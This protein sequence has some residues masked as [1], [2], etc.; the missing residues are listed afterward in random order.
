MTGDR[1]P[2]GERGPMGDKGYP[3]Y[4]GTQGVRGPRGLQGTVVLP[5]PAVFM[6]AA[7]V[8]TATLV[9]MFYMTYIVGAG[10]T[11]D[12]AKA[13]CRIT[14]NIGAY[15]RY[16]ARYN[17][18]LPLERAKLADTFLILHDCD[19]KGRPP[20]TREQSVAYLQSHVAP[21]AHRAGLSSKQF[22]PEFQRRP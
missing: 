15:L 11:D 10:I 6:I 12:R 4:K 18:R 1:G 2:V 16:D 21:E 5:I 20:L 9:A 3:G 14:N 17:A 8:L 13:L 22:S 19:K 7:F